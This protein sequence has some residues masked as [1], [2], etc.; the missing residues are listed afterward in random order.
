MGAPH[1]NWETRNS[2]KELEKRLTKRIVELEQFKEDLTAW[3]SLMGFY[4]GTDRRDV[5]CLITGAFPRAGT[6]D[7][8]VF[9]N[10]D[11]GGG[12]E[13]TGTTLG[14]DV[15]Q[16]RVVLR[17]PAPPELVENETVSEDLADELMSSAGR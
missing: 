3:A 8:V 4:K 16:V 11:S 10:Q 1:S 17:P 5:P 9:D 12:R 14:T 15:N 6:V 7:I 13:V 2:V